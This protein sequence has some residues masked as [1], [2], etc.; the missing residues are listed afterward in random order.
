M[1]VIWKEINLSQTKGGYVLITTSKHDL[2]DMIDKHSIILIDSME[3][4]QNGKASN[5]KSKILD[6]V[7]LA[8]MQLDKTLDRL[9]FKWGREQYE[10]VKSCKKNIMTLV[11]NHHGSCGE[12]FS[13]GNKGNYGM[14]D[15][16]LS[17]LMSQGLG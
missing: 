16:F 3:G 12:Y 6:Y 14:K 9:G 5:A 17:D 10:I 11:N 1:S 13:W 8:V 2:I 4:C 7:L 15:N